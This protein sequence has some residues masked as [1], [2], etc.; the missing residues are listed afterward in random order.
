MGHL[1]YI[2]SRSIIAFALFTWSIPKQIHRYSTS[3]IACTLRGQTCSP[4]H[5]VATRSSLSCAKK[6]YILY[7]ILGKALCSGHSLTLSL[8][9]RVVP[10]KAKRDFFFFLRQIKP[11]SQECILH[12]LTQYLYP[13]RRIYKYNSTIPR[14]PFRTFSYTFFHFKSFFLFF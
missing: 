7:W 1:L 13:F 12:V 9:L 11:L 10:E 2:Q 8:H 4:T 5:T 14:F 6:I 3:R